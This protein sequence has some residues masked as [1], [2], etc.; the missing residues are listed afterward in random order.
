[1]ARYL[2]ES[3]EHTVEHGSQRTTGVLGE[4]PGSEKIYLHVLELTD[5]ELAKLAFR[6]DDNGNRESH[7]LALPRNEEWW[8]AVEGEKAWPKIPRPKMVS[9]CGSDASGAPRPVALGDDDLARL[10]KSGAGNVP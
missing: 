5:A 7:R 4:G 3:H 8:I 9:R 2:V 6:V 10:K 1:M